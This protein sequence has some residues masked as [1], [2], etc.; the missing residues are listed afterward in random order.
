[1][2]DQSQARRPR[3]R[4]EHAFVW[5]KSA[6]TKTVHDGGSPRRRSS[7]ARKSG[8]ELRRAVITLS[9]TNLHFFGGGD[10]AAVIW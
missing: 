3:A 10:N 2:S 4:Y 6:F 5:K 1:M 8:S 7:F 9:L